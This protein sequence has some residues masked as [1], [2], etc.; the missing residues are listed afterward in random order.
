MHAPAQ[1]WDS[2]LLM[3]HSYGGILVLRLA[4][5]QPKRVAGVV[6]LGIGYFE[7]AAEASQSIRCAARL[8]Q[9]AFCERERLAACVASP[10]STSLVLRLAAEQP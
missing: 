6:A 5:E 4:A 7:P 9:G 10:K 2:V 3:G 8:W 1:D